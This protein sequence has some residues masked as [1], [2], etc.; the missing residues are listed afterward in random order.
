MGV[1][2]IG[3]LLGERLALKH[4]RVVSRYLCA[5]A[6]PNKGSEITV[7]GTKRFS[8]DSSDDVYRSG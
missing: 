7:A 6:I 2:L 5:Q 1:C 8:E 3:E 4:I